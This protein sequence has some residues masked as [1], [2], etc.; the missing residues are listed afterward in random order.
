MILEYDVVVWLFFAELCI[1]P[2]LKMEEVLSLH[3]YQTEG[4]E[5]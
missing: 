5:M 4:G 1:N 3:Q 2:A